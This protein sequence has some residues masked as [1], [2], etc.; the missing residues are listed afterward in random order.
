MESYYHTPNKLVP[1]NDRGPGEIAEVALQE[2]KHWQAVAMVWPVYTDGRCNR[3]QECH[4][5][6][7]F[8]TDPRGGKYQYTDDEIL[9]LKVAH[10]RQ[11]HEEINTWNP[12]QETKL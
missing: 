1:L 7:W 3:C 10:L 9:A 5:N 12:R 4:E 6:L 2:L 11:C 8:T